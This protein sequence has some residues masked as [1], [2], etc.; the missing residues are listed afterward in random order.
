[1]GIVGGLLR[2]RHL[3]TLQPVRDVVRLGASGEEWHAPGIDPSFLLIPRRWW[4]PSG[5][6]R[7]QS[8]LVRN[9]SNFTAKLY[10]DIG[11][12]FTAGGFVFV[13]TAADG[14]IDEIISLPRGI[15]GLR[16]DPME[17]T[18]RFIQKP[19]VM[20]QITGL[21]R[22]VRMVRSIARDAANQ[23]GATGAP[24]PRELLGFLPELAQHYSRSKNSRNLAGT[25][26]TASAVL[27][28]GPTSTLVRRLRPNT[29]RLVN[30]DPS[31][32]S[33]LKYRFYLDVFTEHGLSG[34]VVD[35]T[36]PDQPVEVDLY[37]NSEFIERRI[38]SLNR[39]DVASAGHGGPRCGFS[40]PVPPH[41]RLAGGLRATLCPAGSRE[42]LDGQSYIYIPREILLRG[43]LAAV[44]MI[45]RIGQSPDSRV[46]SSLPATIDALASVRQIVFPDLLKR[47]R[48]DWSKLPNV[49]AVPEHP[50]PIAARVDVIIPAYRGLDETVACVKSVLAARVS[51]LFDL[52]VINDRSPEPQLTAAL[53]LLSDQH[54]FLLI[55]HG[56]NMGF[57][58]SVNQG[59]M[60]H[61]ERD[62][63]LLNSD[64]LVADGW[65]DRLRD[66]AYADANIGTVTPFSNRATICS[67]PLATQDNDLPDDISIAQLATACANANDREVIDIP[68]AVGFC[69]YIRRETLRETGYF[70]EVLWGR[71]YGEENDFCLRAAGLGWRHVIACDVFVA[72]HGA[73]SFAGDRSA[74][75]VQN[76]ETLS[77]LYPDYNAT[78]ARFI[79]TDPIAPARRRLFV[80]LAK[81]RSGRYMLFLA[82]SWG[83][84]SHV[85]VTDL[86]QRLATRGE[87]VLILSARSPDAVS[88]SI[89]G[90][91]LTL[92]YHGSGQYEAILDDVRKLNVWH[93]QVHQLPAFSTEIYQFLSKLAIPY[94]VTIHDYYYI[95][96]RIHLVD[97]SERYCG[98]P[99]ES[100]C[101]AC[102]KTSGP[103]EICGDKFEQFGG[104]IGAWRARHSELLRHARLIIAPSGDVAT[105]IGRYFPRARVAVKPH[106][107]PVR[108][109]S[110]TRHAHSNP[111]T[112]AVIGAIG[113]HKGFNVLKACALDA[114]RRSLQLQFVVVGYTCDDA[115]LHGLKSIVITG[116]YDRRDLGDILARHRCTL[117]AFFNVAPETYSYALSEAWV[118]GLYPIVFNLGAQAE[119]VREC[120]FGLVMPPLADAGAINDLL[121]NYAR[122]PRIAPTRS[123]IGTD[124]SNVLNDYYELQRDEDEKATSVA[125]NRGHLST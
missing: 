32:S 34:W 31:G 103:H 104:T 20:T 74:A 36:R 92:E 33:R 67:F 114:D 124:Y 81:S 6:I 93:V 55:E 70:D 5:W 79:Q 65:L 9:G 8:V 102:L 17:S 37:L 7:I 50:A 69:M 89:F 14:T 57:V 115:Q 118:H 96:P 107:E 76:Q 121:I 25:S 97:G 87:T 75:Q 71:G 41:L 52:V 43:A 2:C 88:L 120:G 1:M 109:L 10:Y 64:T 42:P 83:G 108:A 98:E 18:G 29:G 113:V 73:V 27:R 105:R 23:A 16:W 86:A 12:G 47:L 56:E 117:A 123:Y 13:P 119:R 61:E 91:S 99:D 59:M 110:V 49:V 60:L 116:Q 72:H 78:I 100:G 44:E 48:S 38:A 4:H 58:R 111:V 53:K 39:Q 45:N 54:G 122:R 84:G 66:A 19:I 46:S 28:E 112:V 24:R 106:P 22:I 62:V 77:R 40:F 15:V 11:G 63:V 82:H 95:C 68:T 21:E 3:F 51:T 94:D 85:A 35:V 101:A 30:D 80:E 90:T 26:A 125:R